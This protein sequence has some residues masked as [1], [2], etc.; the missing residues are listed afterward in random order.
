MKFHHV[1]MNSQKTLE[2]VLWNDLKALKE[3]CNWES[4]SKVQIL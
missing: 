4:H 1:V 3:F 2:D